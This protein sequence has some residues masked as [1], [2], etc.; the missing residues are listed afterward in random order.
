MYVADELRSLAIKMGNREQ[1]TGT[2]DL[3]S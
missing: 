1:G 2:R 3:G